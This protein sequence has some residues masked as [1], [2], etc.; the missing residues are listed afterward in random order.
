MYKVVV[1]YEEIGEVDGIRKILPRKQANLI[2]MDRDPSM[3]QILEEL[4]KFVPGEIVESSLHIKDEGVINPDKDGRM[5]TKRD[6]LSQAYGKNWEHVQEWADENGWVPNYGIGASKGM[7]WKVLGGVQ[8]SHVEEDTT[9]LVSRWR[10]KS[11]QGIE[12]N[13]GWKRIESREDL[14]DPQNYQVFEVGTMTETGG[15]WQF[16]P[17]SHKVYVAADVVTLWRSGSITHYKPVPDQT[18]AFY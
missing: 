8:R 3:A 18:I 7:D 12:D 2:C 10:L 16:I 17:G 1:Y 13:N 6:A 15:D 11:L 5:K 9:G 4:K 14:P